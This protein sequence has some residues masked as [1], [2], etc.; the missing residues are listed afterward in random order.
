MSF[1]DAYNKTLMNFK[2]FGPRRWMKSGSLNNENILVI[3][4]ALRKL[5]LWDITVVVMTDRVPYNVKQC[6]HAESC[7]DIS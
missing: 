6:T 1:I 3:P 7:M 5:A 2:N 4:R